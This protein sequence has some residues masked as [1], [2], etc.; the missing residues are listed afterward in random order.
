MIEKYDGEVKREMRKKEYALPQIAKAVGNHYR[1]TLRDL[2]SA[3]KQQR[4]MEGRRASS[5]VALEYGYK[6]KEIAEDLSKEPSSVTK[7]VRSESIKP[8][9]EKLIKQMLAENNSNNQV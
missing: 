2:R 6:G 3:A 5:L 4:V 9:M 8:E 1:V 7:Y